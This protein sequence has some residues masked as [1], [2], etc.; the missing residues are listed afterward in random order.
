MDDLAVM[1]KRTLQLLTVL[2]PVWPVARRRCTET[3]LRAG[4]AFDLDRDIPEPFGD[5]QFR[6]CHPASFPQTAYVLLPLTPTS[7][8]GTL[9]LNGS[10]LPS[11]HARSG[12]S[13]LQAKPCFVR[14]VEQAQVSASRDCRALPGRRA[15]SL[16]R[17][18]RRG[19]C[20]HEVP[21]RNE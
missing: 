21:R 18:C 14:E 9:Y 1:V 3:P 17:A 5:M 2:F 11:G 20:P 7:P 13:R 19:G 15:E 8:G 4:G 12:W 6:L 16:R 10:D